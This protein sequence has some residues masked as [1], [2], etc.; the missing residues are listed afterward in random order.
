MKRNYFRRFLGIYRAILFV[1][2]AQLFTLTTTAEEVIVDGIKYDAVKK[3]KQATVI[4]NSYSGDVVIPSSFKYDNVEYDVIAIGASAFSNRRNLT[5]ITIPKSVTSIGSS[6]FY[7]CT[8][9]TSVHITDIAAW[10]NISLEA[11]P[12]I[13]YLMLNIFS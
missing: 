10:C 6:A 13:L 7:D 2:F 11:A 5:S 4:A 8:R 9:F 12:P 3:A 1:L